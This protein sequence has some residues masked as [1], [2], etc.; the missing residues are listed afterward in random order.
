M[1]TTTPPTPE[2][3]ARTSNFEPCAQTHTPEPRAHSAEFRT[4]LRQRVAELK[5]RY[6]RLCEEHKFCVGSASYSICEVTEF[7]DHGIGV[8]WLQGCT[9][10]LVAIARAA[11]ANARAELEGRSE[12][13][14]AVMYKNG[15]FYRVEDDGRC[16]YTFT[17]R[18]PEEKNDPRI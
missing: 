16:N 2:P 18:F 4:W 15:K 3:R 8:P 14:L 13:Y 11:F 1:M 7:E 12:R 6:D 10:P 5:K 17:P 9:H